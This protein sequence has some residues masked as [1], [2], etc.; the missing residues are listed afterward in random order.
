MHAHTI[1]KN[2]L[3]RS[4]KNTDIWKVKVT[5]YLHSHMLSSSSGSITSDHFY[6]NSWVIP[7]GLKNIFIPLLIDLLT[8]SQFS[9]VA[10]SCPTLCNPMNCSTP[11]SLSVTNS[12][13]SPKLMCIESVMPC[14]HLILCRPPLLLPPIPPSIRVFF[15][16]VNS[17]HEVAKVLEFQL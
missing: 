2:K 14:S 3:G 13:S 17:S 11:G 6:L 10:Q 8:F 16:W 4:F 9:S 15:Q 5:V 7:D 1:H 12:R